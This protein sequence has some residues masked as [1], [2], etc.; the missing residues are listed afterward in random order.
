LPALL[1]VS[2][3]VSLALAACGGGGDGGSSSGG[4]ASTQSAASTQS[5]D[6]VAEA[7]KAIAPYVGQPSKPPEL[8][9]L[10]KRSDGAKV[11]LVNQ[12]DPAT[13]AFLPHWENAAKAMGWQTKIVQAG[14]SASTVSSAMDNEVQRNPKG[15]SISSI[16]PQLYQPQLEKLKKAGS[17]VILSGGYE[18]ESILPTI[19]GTPAVTKAGQLLASWVLAKGGDG[20]NSA[21]V[22]TPEIA[23]AVGLGKSYQEEMKRLCPKC[24][25]RIIEVPAAS[26]GS[27][28]PDTIASDLQ[29]HPDTDWV[30]F[31]LGS[32][33]LGLP[34]KLKAAGVDVKTLTF[35]GGTLAAQTL[36]EGGLT[37]D[38]AVDFPYLLWQQA[39]LL[40]RMI[41]KQDI[42][43]EIT[44]TLSTPS[45]FLQKE[46]ITFDP[47]EL[48]QPQEYADMESTWKKLWAGS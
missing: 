34:P 35:A 46:D 8:P 41:A 42:P 39:D 36:K 3:V 1:F 10:E 48:W 31:S 43:K 25:V 2:L 45:Q 18:T 4:N 28:A 26:I 37:A 13:Q 15:M 12:G 20:V 14:T 19:F 23:F 38:L 5:S 47:K 11:D 7:Q 44:G 9:P 33:V 16:P 30:V 22:V 29:S 17:S 32:L 24:K 21:F 40:G 27:K 6:G